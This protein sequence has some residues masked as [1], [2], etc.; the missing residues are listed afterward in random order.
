MNSSEW[1]VL[2]LGCI[3]CLASGAMQPMFAIILIETINVGNIL[4][5][6]I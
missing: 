3:A 2:M 1:F 5:K 4:K 6:K